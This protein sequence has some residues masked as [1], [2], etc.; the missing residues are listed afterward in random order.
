MPEQIKLPG[1]NQ[2]LNVYR[3]NPVEGEQWQFPHALDSDCYNEGISVRE[4]RMLDFINQI[5]DKLDWDR[6]V[7]DENIVRKWRTEACVRS[8]EL[9]DDYLSSTMFDYCIAE[10][11][12]KARYYRQSQMVSVWDCEAAVVKSD[13]VV[14]ATLANS[15]RRTVRV[16][17]EVPDSQKD[18]HPGSEGKV[19]D[20]LHPS[21]FPLIRGRSR[22]LPT[23]TVPLAGCAQRTGDGETVALE[24][25]DRLKAYCKEVGHLL[26]KPLPEWGSFQWLPSNVQFGPDGR[27]KIVSYINNLHPN[28]HLELYGVLEQFVAAAIPLWNECLSWVEPRLRIPFCG[29]SDDDFTVPDGITFTPAAEEV[30]SPDQLRSYTLA[31]AKENDIRWTDSFD[32][33]F[34]ANRVL[35]QPEPEPFRSR[36]QWEA[37]KEHRPVD[38]RQKFA[39]SG[40][41]VIFKLANI[42][43]TP[44]NPEY[45]GGTWHIEGALNEHIVATALY[46]YDEDNITPSHLAF[47]QSLDAEEMRMIPAQGEYRSMELFYGIDSEDPAIQ[48]LGQVQTRCGRLLAFPNILQHR[49]QPFHLADATR[50]GHRKILAMFLVDPH[51]PILSTANVPPQRQDWWAEEVRQVSPFRALPLEIFEMVMQHVDGFPLRW[52]EAVAVRADLMAERGAMTQHFNEEMEEQSFSFCEH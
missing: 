19:L 26:P 7:E 24:L 38:L 23:G 32:N 35:I 11:R 37:R 46:Y 9:E 10:L 14:P 22:A 43:L 28:K 6:K 49:V 15:L 12:D 41:Q 44:D 34:T 17:E 4:R 18:W 45:T 20:L 40:M 29:G 36:E 51:I 50:P 13:T 31:E 21:L 3:P 42:H 47:R 1:F 30:E 39:E 48:R 27:P 8:E 5:T 25:D 33:W 52:D 2:P 16:L